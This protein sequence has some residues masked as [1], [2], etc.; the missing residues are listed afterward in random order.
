MISGIMNHEINL[1]H[2]RKD[3]FNVQQESKTNSSQSNWTYPEYLLFPSS[4]QHFLA[5]PFST[6]HALTDCP[7]TPLQFMCHLT[8][9]CWE[10]SRMKF[11]LLM[12]GLRISKRM[13]ATKICI[14]K[15]LGDQQLWT[16]KPLSPIIYLSNIR[17]IQI[18]MLKNSSNMTT[19]KHK[20][21]VYIH[22]KSYFDNHHHEFLTNVNNLWST[23]SYPHQNHQVH[24]F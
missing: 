14:K 19:Q 5:F 2:Q 24:H 17:H 8:H 10:I 1:F 9:L 4:F 7:H 12:L 6:L 22:M 16:P 15:N 3:P 11:S 21:K 18:D 23:Y 13:S 20:K